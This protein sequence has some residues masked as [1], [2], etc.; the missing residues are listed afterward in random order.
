MRPV[1]LLIA[2][3]TM[4]PIVSGT[5]AAGQNPSGD[6]QRVRAI[7][8]TFTDV[9]NR[10]DIEA[11]TQLFAED[12]EYVTRGG[13]Y[14]RG[15]PEIVRHHAELLAGAFKDSH[16]TWTPLNIRFIRPDVA[17]AHV[18]TDVTFAETVARPP[19]A[20]MV[21]VV[22]VKTGNGLLITVVQNTDL[23]TGPG[24]R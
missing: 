5:D 20:G 17:V 10:A 22:L 13:T 23:P 1:A 18:R 6:E 12:A 15:R 24:Q 8:N 2:L 16:V 3:T 19:G 9:W 4:I 14:L 7:L 21:T 11:F